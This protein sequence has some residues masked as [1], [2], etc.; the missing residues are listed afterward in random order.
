MDLRTTARVAAAATVAGAAIAATLG[1]GADR[2]RP[3][4][5]GAAAALPTP[6]GPRVLRAM[7]VGHSAGGRPIHV[8]AAGNPAAARRLLVV[9]CIHGTECAGMAVTR[10][11]VRRLA[12]RPPAGADVWALSDL[13][14]DGRAAG[15]RLN[16]HG[17]DLNRNF[18]GGWRPI[19][20][21]GD[22]EHS[23][24]R[25]FSEPE[26]RT[27]R[28]IVH[29]LRPRVTVWFHQQANPLV[30]AW[31]PSIPVARRYARLA[32]LPFRPLRW[33]AGTAPHWQHTAFPGTASFVVELAPGP[34]GAA[35]A[36]R[37]VRAV[38]ALAGL[39]DRAGRG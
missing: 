6:T 10:G 19:G 12:R 38:L 33:L 11:I 4:Q 1:A 31:G 13:D 16:G 9:G 32:R 2:D 5:R 8:T 35:A 18:R 20:R 39:A 28:S 23:G 24:P 14:P 3:T 25:P 27:A 37:H 29:A 26:T 30:R 22:L 15:S 21:P 17:V 7:R 36:R 34:L